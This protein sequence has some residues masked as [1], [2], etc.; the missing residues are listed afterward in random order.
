VGNKTNKGGPCV[1]K[2]AHLT[3]DVVADAVWRV[4]YLNQR[5]RHKAHI[6]TLS[7]DQGSRGSCGPA[8]HS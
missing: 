7:G 6:S 1:E 5:G 3:D 8:G 4:S 2:P